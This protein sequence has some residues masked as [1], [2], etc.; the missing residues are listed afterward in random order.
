M[1]TE[2]KE[3]RIGTLELLAQHAPQLC[4]WLASESLAPED[5]ARQREF[6]A[7][8]DALGR[9]Q[10]WLLVNVAGLYAEAHT[11]LKAMK[12]ADERL[13]AA[14]KEVVAAFDQTGHARDNRTKLSRTV[15]QLRAELRDD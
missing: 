11:R 5:V 14:A 6:W 7:F 12:G 4:A 15:N 3:Q 2:K 8:V 13:V 10:E 9:N 1:T